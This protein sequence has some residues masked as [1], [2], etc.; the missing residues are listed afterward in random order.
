[1]TTS[2]EGAGA[3]L[4]LLT[5][6]LGQ[7]VSTTGAPAP[8][9]RPALL[10]AGAAPALVR[11]SS[12]PRSRPM[13]RCSGGAGSGAAIVSP[14][15][16]RT[17]PPW[18]SRSS[19]RSPPA[20]CAPLNPAY[21]GEELDFYLR[22]LRTGGRR[23][24]E[25][26][27]HSLA[28]VARRS[29]FLSSSST[30]RRMSPERARSTSRA[31]LTM[32]GARA[33]PRPDDIALLLHTS[34]TTA[35]RSSCRCRTR[36]WRLR[37]GNVAGT[38][39]LTADDRCLNVMPL[40]HIHGLVAALLAS[41]SSG[42][43]VVC[44]P[45]F[46]RGS[47]L[48]WLDELEPTWYTAV[49][50][51]HQAVLARASGDAAASP[52]RSALIRSSSAA[53]PPSG[54]A[55]EL[56][57]AFGV[58]VI[59]AYGM[60][61]AA[62]QMAS[63]PLPPRRAQAG[64]RRPGRGPG[65]RGPRRDGAPA[66]AGEI[67]EIVDPGSE[68]HAGYEREPEANAAAFADGWFRTGD[69]GSLDE[70]GYLF[71]S[72]RLKEIINRG[73]EKISPARGRGGAARRIPASPRPSRSRCRTALGEDVGAAVVL[74]DGAP[75]VSE[76]RTARLRRR[77]ARRLQGSARVRRSSTRS[78]KGATGKVQRVGLSQRLKIDTPNRG[79][80]TWSRAEGRDRAPHH[81]RVRRSPRARRAHRG[82]RR[83]L[84]PGRGLDAP[85]RA[86]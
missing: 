62:H 10:S 33:R 46:R 69:Q 67:G 18:R 49:P 79:S 55:D 22:D 5:G 7:R 64:L 61:E 82:D 34:G 50:T 72:G 37:P 63:N 8:V 12:T 57:R 85:R 25:R 52:R 2:A 66:A 81:R 75:T 76:G 24:R 4:A 56:E 47:F 36:I 15:W 29:T 27:R 1:M 32:R 58:P 71:I 35:G 48:E 54:P 70:D 6:I 84:R 60:T 51:I 23:G 78:R 53:L 45:G 68:R 86:A 43:S 44:T 77:A 16:S 19:G 20:V 83:L 38:L 11:C 26:P 13:W 9:A 39:A 59:E 42:R 40:F 14:S 31:R 30:P 74:A 65:D 17:A 80:R 21:T 3:G 41:L 28:E 73:G